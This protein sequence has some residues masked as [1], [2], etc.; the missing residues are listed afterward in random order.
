MKEIKGIIVPI[1]TPMNA[2]ES[3]NLEQLRIQIDRMIEAG[4]QGIFCFGTNGEGYILTDEEK[5]TVL[6]ATVEAGL[7]DPR[8]GVCGHG[9]CE[10]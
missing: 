7:R 10:H 9:L 4:V 2:D 8:P 1:V 3:V 5:V 6:T